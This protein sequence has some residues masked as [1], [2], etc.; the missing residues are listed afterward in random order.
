MNERQTTEQL[1]R[2]ASA[3]PIDPTAAPG[4][5]V[6]GRSAAGGRSAADTHGGAM[7]LQTVHSNAVQG[8]AID[9]PR[10][11]RQTVKSCSASSFTETSLKTSASS[12]R[13]RQSHTGSD[14]AGAA[15]ACDG[16]AH[17]TTAQ[18]WRTCRRR[19]QAC[20][21]RPARHAARASSSCAS[22]SPRDP[23]AAGRMRSAR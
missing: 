9:R 18:R 2:C 17:V 7:R 12:A 10:G 6:H 1:G 21:R 11:E 15:C 8:G 3:V 23:R 16:T 20:C 4:S 22:C 14:S 19:P 5:S 13:L